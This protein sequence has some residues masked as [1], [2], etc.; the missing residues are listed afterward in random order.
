MLLVLIHYGETNWVFLTVKIHYLMV[1]LILHIE[2]TGPA[3]GRYI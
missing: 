1:A 3:N 2:C